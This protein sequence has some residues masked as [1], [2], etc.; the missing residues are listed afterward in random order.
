MQPP[1]GITSGPFE[2]LDKL[3][4]ADKGFPRHPERRFPRHPERRSTEVCQVVECGSFVGQKVLGDNPCPC[5]VDLFRL[6]RQQNPYGIRISSDQK[7]TLRCF[8]LICELAPIQR[9]HDKP[10]MSESIG[11]FRWSGGFDLNPDSKGLIEITLRLGVEKVADPLVK[12]ALQFLEIRR[13]F[14][15]P[16]SRFLCSLFCVEQGGREGERESADCAPEIR[17]LSRMRL[18][19]G[20]IVFVSGGGGGALLRARAQIYQVWVGGGGGVGGYLLLAFGRR[21]YVSK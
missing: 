3:V 9:D 13:G 19:G 11:Q 5:Q 17:G 7:L 20:S 14:G 16:C 1:N 6:K 18:G 4:Q 8:G 10:S 2:F 15:I 21:E 12:Q